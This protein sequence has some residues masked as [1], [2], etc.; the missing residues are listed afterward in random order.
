MKKVII[1]LFGCTLIQC[2]EPNKSEKVFIDP[3][4]IAEL[5]DFPDLSQYR[6]TCTESELIATDFRSNIVHIFDYESLEIVESFGGSG[7]GPGELYGA[8]H[9]LSDEKFVYISNAGNQSISVFNKEDWSYHSI[10]PQVRS[11]SRFTVTS[12][13][14]YLSSPFE[15]PEIPFI[16]KNLAE[17]GNAVYFG[18]GFE[19]IFFG[20]NIFNLL[21]YQDKILAISQSEPVIQLY[22][23][24]GNQLWV[25]N[26]EDEP[27]LS[28]TMNFIRQFYDD[29]DNQN[30]TVSLFNDAAVSGEYIVLNFY[31][32]VVGQFKT[33]DYLV[34]KIKEYGLDSIS[35][36][37]TNVGTG[38]YTS[39][40]CIHENRLYSNGGTNGLDLYVFDL[41][42][43]DN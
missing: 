21:M 6:L 8:M 37:E 24:E 29:S 14:I 18:S 5:M 40:F 1:I 10:I 12:D 15:N 28:E 38:G 34:Y 26:I 11:V 35:S 3:D 20:R 33:N 22:D 19:N 16:K 23:R 41:T 25:Q 36:F 31:S 43:I 4:Q 2:S 30:K 27:A 17:A 7:R 9:S 13:H 39:T 32:R 42:F